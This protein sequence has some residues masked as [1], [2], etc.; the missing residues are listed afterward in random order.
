MA[1]PY[2]Y[3]LQV[4]SLRDHLRVLWKKAVRNPPL[5]TPLL[6]LPHHPRTTASPGEEVAKPEHSSL[7]LPAPD[8][9]V[10]AV[11]VVELASKSKEPTDAQLVNTLAL[12]LIK[13]EFARHRI[14]CSVAHALRQVKDVAALQKEHNTIMAKFSSRKGFTVSHQMS[15]SRA[16]QRLQA[17]YGDA[18]PVEPSLSSEYTDSDLKKLGADFSVNPSSLGARIHNIWTEA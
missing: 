14:G 2:H 15:L 10:M 12:C 16:T 17:E 4:I 1:Y 18:P 8:V 13:I 5:E 3:P 11:G 6:R 7:L 9:T